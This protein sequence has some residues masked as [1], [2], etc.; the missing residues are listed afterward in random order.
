MWGQPRVEVKIPHTRCRDRMFTWKLKDLREKDLAAFRVLYFNWGTQK[1]GALE[2]MVGSW[3]KNL[4]CQQATQCVS[5]HPAILTVTT[6]NGPLCKED[7][8]RDTL[9]GHRPS[10]TPGG[11]DAFFLI[12][13]KEAE[14]ASGIS[15]SSFSPGNPSTRGIAKS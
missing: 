12:P 13:H 4:E 3:G 15:G 6:N 5:K 1:A 10:S 9:P 11:R 8:A 14:W 2:A 7:W